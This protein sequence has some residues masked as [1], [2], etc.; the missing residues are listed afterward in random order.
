VQNQKR[1]QKI[2]QLYLFSMM[3]SVALMV[4][5][6][7]LQAGMSPVR[8]Q[9]RSLNFFQFTLSFQPHYGPGAY[10]TS[11]RLFFVIPFYLQSV[12]VH[13]AICVKTYAVTC[14]RVLH[15]TVTNRLIFLWLL[16][17]KLTNQTLKTRITN[18]VTTLGIW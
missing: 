13:S 3:I 18:T 15:S 10:S 1:S 7:W 17:I 14:R 16:G 5:T 4:E 11:S 8:V 12:L 6:L 2:K 9:M